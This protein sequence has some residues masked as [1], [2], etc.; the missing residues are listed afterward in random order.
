MNHRAIARLLL[1]RGADPKADSPVSELF[2]PGLPV[3]FSKRAYGSETGD[4]SIDHTYFSRPEPSI[5]LHF[6]L[7]PSSSTT[8]LRAHT[9]FTPCLLV[10]LVCTPAGVCVPTS[11]RTHSRERV[12]KTNNTTTVLATTM[13]CVNNTILYCYLQHQQLGTPEKCARV[14]N[15]NKLA[16]E[17]AK[18]ARGEGMGSPRSSPSSRASKSL[19]SR[20]VSAVAGSRSSTSSGTSPSTSRSSSKEKSN[21]KRNSVFARRKKKS[22]KVREE[23]DVVQYVKSVDTSNPLFAH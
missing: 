19:H 3:Q 7:F 1:E 15:H 13:K 21:N 6:V 10:L 17:L 18:C 9:N 16:N 5:G 2:L 14:N 23:E 20:V 4:P 11:L 22:G 12:H 8:T